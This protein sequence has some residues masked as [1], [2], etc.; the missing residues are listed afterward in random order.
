MF[1]IFQSQLWALNIGVLTNQNIMLRKSTY[2]HQLTQ[3]FE[4][5][6]IKWTSVICDNRKRRRGT[7]KGHSLTAF[8]GGKDRCQKTSSDAPLAIEVVLL[9]PLF[10]KQSILVFVGWSNKPKSGSRYLTDC[11]WKSKFFCFPFWPF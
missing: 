10:G 11:I 2:I 3:S 5:W 1:L 4:V 9:K 7:L 6:L 8:F